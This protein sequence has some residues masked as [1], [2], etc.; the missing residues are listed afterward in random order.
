MT[1]EPLTIGGAVV[2]AFFCVFGAAMILFRSHIWAGAPYRL[3]RPEY[4]LEP[5][6]RDDVAIVFAGLVIF[7]LGGAVLGVNL[8]ALRALHDPMV[9]HQAEVTFY[10]AVEQA[11]V[12]GASFN[13]AVIA[14]IRS[15]RGGRSVGSTTSDSCHSKSCLGLRLA[16]N[17]QASWNGLKS[18]NEL[19]TKEKEHARWSGN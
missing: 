11:N 9:L 12:E 2:G 17:G 19:A 10:Q 1:S 4:H 16:H 6:G 15:K 14:F 18:M 8:F 7:A 13:D 3:A 5:G